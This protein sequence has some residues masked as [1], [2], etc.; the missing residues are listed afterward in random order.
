MKN[1]FLLLALIVFSF[2]AYGETYRT[3]KNLPVVNSDNI[4]T[5]L[6]QLEKVSNL[7]V[8]STVI[9]VYHELKF[10]HDFYFLV[11]KPVKVLIH[12]PN[13]VIRLNNAAITLPYGSSVIGRVTENGN[14]LNL[15][16]DRNRF[17]IISQPPTP[18]PVTLTYFKASKSGSEALIYWH[19]A[20]EVDFSHFE[21]Q[22][23]HDGKT[24]DVI[25]TV[26]A[27]GNSS[28]GTKYSF[29][30]KEYQ[31]NGIVYY[32]LV[33]VDID[34]SREYFSIQTIRFT[35]TDLYQ[36]SNQQLEVY[37]KYKV[38]VVDMSGRIIGS[39]NQ[40]V[41]PF[42]NMRGVYILTIYTDQGVFREKIYVKG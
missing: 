21:I 1:I 10:N 19:T 33:A 5:F 28:I 23:S 20:S 32:R 38:D 17:I 3:I 4:N 12:K 37:G 25:G 22:R 8:D 7:P 30:H 31:T 34:G 9:N 15:Y 29:N 27:K 41:I 26:V 11:Y 35:F 36:L 40:D 13:G 6:S 14:E 18:L 24:F 2:T 39:Y 16:T 42:Q